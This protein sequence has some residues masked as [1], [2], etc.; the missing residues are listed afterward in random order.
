MV[1]FRFMNNLLA[2]LKTLTL[3][4]VAALT[5]TTPTVFPKATPVPVPAPAKNIIVRSGEYSYSGY[6]L[7]YTLRIPKDGGK[8]TGNFS[9]ACEGPITG[10]FDGKEGGKVTGEAQANCKIVLFTYKLKA[11]Y[12]AKLYLNQGKVDVD[13]TG[14]MPYVGDQGSFTIYFEPAD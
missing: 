5:A 7:K 13:W 9:D 6:T 12:E 8:V 11:N 3:G 1:K 14:K 2:G 10:N 4:L